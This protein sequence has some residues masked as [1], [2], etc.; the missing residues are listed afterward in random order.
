[1]S[2]FSNEPS[3]EG[4]F[5]IRKTANYIKTN[6]KGLANGLLLFSKQKNSKIKPMRLS[7]SLHHLYYITEKIDNSNLGVDVGPLNI[8]LDNPNH[9]PT[10]ISF[11][12]NNAKTKNIDS[13]TK[14]ITSIS[15]MRSIVSNASVFWRNFSTITD[16]KLIKNDIKYLY[17]SFTKIPCLVITPK[18][19]F[20][21]I[22]GYEEY[23][24][25]T[26]VPLKMFKNL[27]VLE[28][29]ECEPNEVFGW[30][31][32]S[33]Q[34]RVLIIK[35]SKLSDLTE[36]IHTLVNDDE[37]GRSS[38]SKPI[39][40]P[41]TNVTITTNHTILVDHK[42]A[43]SKDLTQHSNDVKWLFLKQL[44]VVETSIT[45]I[46]SFAFKPLTN[47]VKL[48]LSNNLL[49]TIPEG[50]EYLINI[51]YINLSDNYITSLQNLPNNL[52]H[53]SILSFNNNKLD[54]LGG[55][56]NLASLEKLDLRKNNLQTINALKPIV[57]LFTRLNT[58]NNVYLS[59]NK[60][61]K[62]YRADLFNLINGIKFKNSFKIDDSRPG[63][64]ESALLLDNEAAIK[65]LHYYFK[66]LKSSIVELSNSLNLM[67]LQGHQ[68]LV[69]NQNLINQVAPDNNMKKSKTLDNISGK[70]SNNLSK[71]KNFPTSMITPVQVTARTS[72]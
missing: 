58:F 39:R 41:N 55:L 53:L 15:S 52:K 60:L 22:Q 13:D 14:S 57:C 21:G 70:L 66:N 65:N 2:S 44:T 67:D 25:D 54:S 23:P 27:Q 36:L 10:F 43:G 16:P 62:S 26:S 32:L 37:N 64:F 24:C 51:K 63:Y 31:I 69:L 49:H 72:T 68:P 11:M 48:N 9:E 34:L 30:N 59:N 56:E 1:M 47:L 35:N 12:A 50:L 28:I 40:R 29:V 61:P 33:E 4:D 6:E 7:F 46:P 3:I 45:S 18:T 71:S 38:F 17:S 8:R 42:R 20:N 5:F 19:K